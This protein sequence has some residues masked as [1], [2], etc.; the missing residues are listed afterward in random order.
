MAEYK[1]DFDGWN[2]KK[3]E[4]NI[5]NTNFH[6][7]EK[8][9]WWC[10][11]GINIGL[12]KDGKGREF[13]RPVLILKVINSVTFICIP[14]TSKLKQNDSHI[15]FYFEYEFHTAV[16]AEIKVYDKRRLQNYIGKVS[17]YLYTKMKKAAAA[18]ILS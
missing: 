13:T 3:K 5:K 17:D 14:I 6:F 11:M 1:K 16:I 12:E 8:E 4:I 7:Y 2:E 15:S 9:I 18:Y 10:H